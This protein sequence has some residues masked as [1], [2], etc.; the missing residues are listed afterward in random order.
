MHCQTEVMGIHIMY[1]YTYLIYIYIASYHIISYHIISYHIIYI[2]IYINNY[3]YIY[4]H[5]SSP[6]P[7][8][9]IFIA[10]SL[11]TCDTLLQVVGPKKNKQ[12]PGPRRAILMADQHLMIP[13]FGWDELPLLPQ[14]PAMLGCSLVFDGFCRRL[15]RSDPSPST[16]FLHAAVSPPNSR[17]ELEVCRSTAV[18]QAAKLGCAC[19]AKMRLGPCVDEVPAA[20]NNSTSIY[21]YIINILWRVLHIYASSL[22]LKKYEPNIRVSIPIGSMYGIY[23]NIWGILVVNVTIYSIH[24]SYG[25]W[26]IVKVTSTSVKSWSWKMRHLGSAKPWIWRPFSWRPQ[27]S[28]D[29][30]LPKR[31]THCLRDG[32]KTLAMLGKMMIHSE[33]TKCWWFVPWIFSTAFSL[34]NNE[35]PLKILGPGLG[36]FRRPEGHVVVVS[37]GFG[38]HCA[39]PRIVRQNPGKYVNLCESM[40]IYVNLC[41]STWIYVNLCESMWIW[42]FPRLIVNFALARLK[43]LDKRTK[44]HT[45]IWLVLKPSFWANDR[46]PMGSWTSWSGLFTSCQ[47]DF[48]DPKLEVPTIY[49]AYFLGLCKGTSP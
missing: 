47:W 28:I 46:T 7:P 21:I 34:S 6:V 31:W 38:K 22:S 11:D 1:A 8:S 10:S 40:W 3:I 41:E 42:Q 24:G 15:G 36:T 33:F 48:Q 45:H 14:L 49:K 4:T 44:K 13:I 9:Y 30:L 35:T 16:C 37:D 18:S 19:A 32:R 12:N 5:Q 2:Y 29:A 17:R 39:P 27:K 23:A 25:I 26:H 20:R 43:I